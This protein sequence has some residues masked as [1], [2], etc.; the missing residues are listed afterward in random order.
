LSE[1]GATDLSAQVDF[2]ALSLAARRAGA[3]VVR[4]ATQRD[5][6]HAMGGRERFAALRKANPRRAAEFAAAER[7]LTA[8]EEMGTLFKVMAIVS[9]STGR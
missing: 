1:P 2:A 3:A 6:L 9:P 7:R 8:P 5:F 4:P